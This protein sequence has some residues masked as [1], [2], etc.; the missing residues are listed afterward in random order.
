MMAYDIYLEKGYPI[1]T[2]LVEGTCGSLVEDRME[3]SG[4]RWSIAG[5]QAVLEQRAVVKNNDWED[6]WAFYIDME[7]LRLY[8]TPYERV[9]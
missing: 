3:Q 8:P 4:M 2:G 6:F 9:A 5:A 1:A 7:T